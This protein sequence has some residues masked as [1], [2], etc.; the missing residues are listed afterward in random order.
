MKKVA[1]FVLTVLFLLQLGLPV[2]ALEAEPPEG[3][4]EETPA[5]GE[6][7]VADSGDTVPESLPVG[8]TGDIGNAGNEAE[9]PETPES[10]GLS[11]AGGEDVQPAGQELYASTEAELRTALSAAAG[12]ETDLG[13]IEVGDNIALSSPIVVASGKHVLLSGVA[14]E[15]PRLRAGMAPLTM[16]PSSWWRRAPPWTCKI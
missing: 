7:P 3:L 11:A 13:T 5:A 8:D 14:E 16:A 6:G 10:D 2:Y 9:A 15:R 4:P 1:S 12:S